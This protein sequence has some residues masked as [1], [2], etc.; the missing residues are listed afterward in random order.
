[1]RH[2][3]HLDDE[4]TPEQKADLDVLLSLKSTE[5]R[6]EWADA[7]GDEGIS[8][9]LALLEIAALKELERDTEHDDF[10]DAKIAISRIM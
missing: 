10:I 6:Q 9:G 8:Y 4:L 2:A 1:M 7:V 5:M 3:Y